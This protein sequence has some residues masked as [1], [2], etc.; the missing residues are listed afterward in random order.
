[1]IVSFDYDGTLENN[2]DVLKELNA[3][4]T[5]WYIADQKGLPFN[6]RRREGIEKLNT[7]IELIK[8]K[9]DKIILAL[10]EVL[11]GEKDSVDILID[12]LSNNKIKFFED[13]TLED[14]LA[15]RL[16]NIIKDIKY[17][18]YIARYFDW[19]RAVEDLELEG[20]HQTDYGVIYIED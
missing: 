4:K 17:F 8:D 13:Y 5:N 2:I 16:E 1:M 19:E 3:S 10:S 14:V 11:Y 12:M 6:L 18:D 9:H 7:L 20:Y 15:E